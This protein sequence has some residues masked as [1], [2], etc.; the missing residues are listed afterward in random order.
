MPDE[1]TSIAPSDR[2]DAALKAVHEELAAFRLDTHGRLSRIEGLQ[3]GFKLAFDQMDKRLNT[4]QWMVGLVIASQVL[5]LGK[6][7]LK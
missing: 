4:M 7:F 3:E 1:R 5:I 6:L 2:T